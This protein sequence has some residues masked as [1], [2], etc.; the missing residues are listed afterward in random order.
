MAA[1]QGDRSRHVGPFHEYGDREAAAR[2]KQQAL[3]P[4]AAA[5]LGPGNALAIATATL[6]VIVAVLRGRRP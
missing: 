3:L 2:T 1:Q 4:A 5:T 6:I